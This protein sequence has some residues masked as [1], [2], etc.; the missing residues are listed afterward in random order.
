[1]PRLNRLPQETSKLVALARR[2]VAERLG[3]LLRG[4]NT[5]RLR[6]SCQAARGGGMSS[7]TFG[8]PHPGCRPTYPPQPSCRSV[9]SSSSWTVSGRSVIRLLLP[10]AGR[11]TEAARRSAPMRRTARR[12]SSRRTFDSAARGVVRPGDPGEDMVEVGTRRDFLLRHRRQRCE[13][14]SHCAYS[15]APSRSCAPVCARGTDPRACL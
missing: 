13:G 14:P 6:G 7:R 5:L 9:G 12:H 10:S 3:L 11:T 8:F 4:G 2:A 15:A 1:M